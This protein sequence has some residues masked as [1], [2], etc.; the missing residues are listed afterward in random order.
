MGEIVG[1]DDACLFCE[2]RAEGFEFARGFFDCGEIG[3]GGFGEV[4][5]VVSHAVEN[6]AVGAEG[7]PAASAGK[8]FH[9]QEG[10]FQILGP[11]GRPLEGEVMEGASE[12]A[13]PIEDEF[14]L[15]ARFGAVSEA[16]ADVGRRRHGKDFASQAAGGCVNLPA[17]LFSLNREKYQS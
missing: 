10:F 1:H 8:G 16:R 4:R 12:M 9:D 11:E 6:E 14:A 7:V 15:G 2:G 13:H 5:G 3:G 17:Q